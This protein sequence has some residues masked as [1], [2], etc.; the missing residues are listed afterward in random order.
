MFTN[1]KTEVRHVLTF[2]G[3]CETGAM[4][5]LDHTDDIIVAGGPLAVAV[6]NYIRDELGIE[7]HNQGIG[8]G[9]WD[10][11]VLGDGADCWGHVAGQV[12]HRFKSAW[13]SRL[14]FATA[15]MAWW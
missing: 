9:E 15:K 4:A 3:P 14:L 10:V 11:G 12:V 5:A 1:P 8:F 7:I 6:R 13:M 2:H